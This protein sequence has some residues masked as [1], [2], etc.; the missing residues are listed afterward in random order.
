M[1]LEIGIKEDRV[2]FVAS[3]GRIMFEV[4]PGKDGKS[5]E[6]RGVET[7]LV[8]GVLYSQFIDIRPI[9]GNCVQ[10]MV[11]LYDE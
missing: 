7:C 3:D 9:V 2:S 10:I 5:I 4:K 8:D 11:R 6:V 1:K